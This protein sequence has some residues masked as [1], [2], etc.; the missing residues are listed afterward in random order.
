VVAQVT[1]VEKNAARV[2][3]RIAAR[4]AAGV[5]NHRFV[6]LLPLPAGAPARPEARAEE[7]KPAK[8]GG[9]ARRDPPKP[10]HAPR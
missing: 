7:K 1:S 6:M 4:P 10:A 5:E 3:A 9:K 2:F 8:G